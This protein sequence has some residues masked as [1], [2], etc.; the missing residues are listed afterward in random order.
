MVLCVDEK[1]RTQAPERTRPP[2]PLGLGY[3]EGIRRGSF[4]S[5]AELK[6]KILRFTDEYNPGGASVRVDRHRRLDP[7]ADT[8]LNRNRSGFRN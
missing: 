3:V 8:K 6:R 5:V 4:S 7:L 2:L 1:T